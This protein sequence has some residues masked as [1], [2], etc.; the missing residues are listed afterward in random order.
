M[1]VLEASQIA[2]PQMVQ[3]FER[4]GGEGPSEQFGPYSGAPLYYNK[5]LVPNAVNGHSWWRVG[6]VCGGYLGGTA[7]SF[8]MVS[9]QK[10][11]PVILGLTVHPLEDP[12][13]CET[14]F[15]L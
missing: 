10:R 15:C 8:S 2:T 5:N 12:G 6:C 3:H 1:D 9:S 11:S 13:P 4:R 14:C 7:A